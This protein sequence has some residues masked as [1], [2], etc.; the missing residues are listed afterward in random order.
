MIWYSVIYDFDCVHGHVERLNPP[1]KQRR[2]L[3]DCTESGPCEDNH[4]DTEHW[5]GKHRKWCAILNQ[6]QFDEFVEHCDLYASSTPTMGS[7]G[8][9]GY[10]FGWAP[11]ICF[12]SEGDSYAYQNAYV[13]PSGTRQEL[14]DFFRAHERPVPEVLLE[15]PDQGH[16]PEDCVYDPNRVWGTINDIIQEKYAA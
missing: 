4:F 8:A 6:E 13:T 12:Q 1:K 5:R 11:A 15:H 16:V 3:W 9:P 10:G 7:I 2:K 14:I